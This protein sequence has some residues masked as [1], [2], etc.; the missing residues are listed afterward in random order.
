MLIL[1]GWPLAEQSEGVVPD[2]V[3]AERFEDAV[4]VER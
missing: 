2:F 1:A 3:S 4:G